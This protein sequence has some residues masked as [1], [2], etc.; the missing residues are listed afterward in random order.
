MFGGFLGLM[1]G[2]VEWNFSMANVSAQTDLEHIDDS[3]P[4]WGFHPSAPAPS[5]TL[6]RQWDS[7]PGTPRD[8]GSFTQCAESLATPSIRIVSGDTA[9]L[10][11]NELRQKLETIA[12]ERNALRVENANLKDQLAN[13]LG[14]LAENLP[15]PGRA[16]SIATTVDITQPIGNDLVDHADF[17]KRIYNKLLASMASRVRLEREAN[18][19]HRRY[20]AER[21]IHAENLDKAMAVIAEQDQILKQTEEKLLYESCLKDVR[22]GARYTDTGARFYKQT[23]SVSA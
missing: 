20:A 11:A 4:Q 5:R 12:A 22:H 10:E 16:Q 23:R 14:V 7:R 15:S 2:R 1:R 9:D 6:L 17:V 21:R 3:V 18:L 13:Q 19:L 8:V